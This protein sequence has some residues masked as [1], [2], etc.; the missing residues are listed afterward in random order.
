MPKNEPEH[1]IQ[2][3]IRLALAPHAIMLR[4]NAGT[5]WQGK[6][7][8]DDKRK[9]YILI[10]IRPVAGVPEGVSDLIGLRRSD[11]K[12]VAVECK[13]NT[14]TVRPEQERFIAAVQ[15]AHALAGVARCEE[16]AVKIVE[17]G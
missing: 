14:G 13:T 11:G 10:N 4:V 7:I 9:Q 17:G 1:I 5:F 15:E 3:K 8:W 2:S 12:F 6:R 16:D